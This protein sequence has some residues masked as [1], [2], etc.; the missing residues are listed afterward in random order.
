MLK[1]AQWTQDDSRTMRIATIIALLYLP[2][3]LILSF[4]STTFVGFRGAKLPQDQLDEILIVHSQA[5]IAGALILVAVFGT[6]VWFWVW[7]RRSTKKP[8][9][10]MP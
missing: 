10:R 9:N 3:N 4:F 5:W 2:A 1:I 7:D 8:L 6:T